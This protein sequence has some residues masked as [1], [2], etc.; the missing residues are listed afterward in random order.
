MY[1]KTSKSYLELKNTLDEM[2]SLK[3]QVLVIIK[4]LVQEGSCLLLNLRSGLKCYKSQEEEEVRS[5][6][7]EAPSYELWRWNQ[8]WKKSLE[9]RRAEGRPEMG[10]DFFFDLEVFITTNSTF[11]LQSER[12]VKFRSLE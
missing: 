8:A 2:R 5:P 3:N 9:S 12:H 11:S 4:R 6:I 1:V 7:M 10:M